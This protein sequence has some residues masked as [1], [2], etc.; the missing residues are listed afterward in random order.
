MNYSSQVWEI[1]Q[2]KFFENWFGKLKDHRAKQ[3]IAQRLVRIESGL[4]G[5]VKFFDSIGEIRIREGP[6]YRVYF[7]KRSSRIIILLCGGNKSSQQS[8][9]KQAKRIAKELS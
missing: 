8:D 5:D 3:R 9:I 6:G 1:R 2:T 4:L 7:V